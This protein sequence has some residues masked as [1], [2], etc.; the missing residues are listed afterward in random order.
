MHAIQVSK[1][2]GP[3]ELVYASADR[4]KPGKGE[5]LVRLEAGDIRPVRVLNL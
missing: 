1:T 4:P 5:A 2:G 3:E